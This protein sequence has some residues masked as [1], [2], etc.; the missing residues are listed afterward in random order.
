MELISIR[1]PPSE[2]T[3]L[4]S[5]P[6][7]PQSQ[8]WSS[9][10]Q[11]L[12][13]SL[14]NLA[15]TGTT[16]FHFPEVSPRGRHKGQWLTQWGLFSTCPRDRRYWSFLHRPSFQLSP[17]F[18]SPTSCWMPCH[19]NCSKRGHYLP[20]P[21]LKTFL[22]LPITHPSPPKSPALNICSKGAWARLV[23]GDVH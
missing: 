9:F 11:V 23:L 4:L 6:T 3:H 1:S 17:M 10:L 21:S 2:E 13:F 18:T 22:W 14:E 8:T 15:A 7:P 16:S 5:K 12:F 19:P 20:L